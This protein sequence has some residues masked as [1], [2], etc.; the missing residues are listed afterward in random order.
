MR[1][2]RVPARLSVPMKSV[3]PL[4]PAVIESAP[5][6]PHGKS[7]KLTDGGGLH[8]L[9]KDNGRRYWRLKFRLFGDEKMYSIGPYPDVG[10]EAAR[11]AARDARKLINRGIN[12]TAV[13]REAK[14]ARYVATVTTFGKVGREFLDRKLEA[15]APATRRKL[16]WQYANLSAL[17]DRPIGDLRA[18]DVINVLRAIEAKDHREAAHRV[19]QF[20]SR[21]FRFA[22][23]MNY[24]QVNPVA[25][26]REVLKP[27][28][29]KSHA[30]I[31]DPKL[32]GELMQFIDAD[33]IGF[34]NVRHGLQLL[35]RTFVRPGELRQA[36]WSEVDFKKAEWR[37]PASRMKMRREHLVPLSTQAAEILRKQ[38]EITG[39]GPL[40]FPGLRSGRPMSDATMGAALKLIFFDSNMHVP[41]GF[42]VSAS[43][44]LH[45][46]GYDPAVIELQLSHAKR[47]KV[48]GIYDRSQRVPERR[49]M[50][51]WWSDY[52]EKLKSDYIERLQLIKLKL[53][54]RGSVA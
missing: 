2:L 51:Q 47:D 20:A 7:K 8:L 29:V 53:M 18:P 10:V 23:Q 31:T 26:L 54:K 17:F 12:P 6:P 9:I 13:Q 35:A 45:E 3:S 25:D 24:C 46:N 38:Y 19:G 16:D 5:I 40:V 34:A 33:Y 21:V 41:H 28:A 15:L 4:T 50:M 42:R 27:R 32:F 52:I 36:L 44:L 49:A 39:S 22:V 48:A 1:A 30:G 14:T 43:T 11:Q 37:I